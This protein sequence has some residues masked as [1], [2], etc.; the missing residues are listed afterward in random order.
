MWPSRRKSRYLVS[1]IR[2]TRV[3]WA[4]EQARALAWEEQLSNRVWLRVHYEQ[5]L[6]NPRGNA[7]NMCILGEQ[8]E[9][10]YVEK[11]TTGVRVL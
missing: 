3:L 11:S 4:Q 8:Y 10:R 5:L 1:T 6:E 9:P 2:T 7:K